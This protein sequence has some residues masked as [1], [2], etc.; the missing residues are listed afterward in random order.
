MSPLPISQTDQTT[1]SAILYQDPE[2]V[3]R[4]LGNGHL[5][6]AWFA[7]DQ[8]E[9][10]DYNRVIEGVK[11]IGA[12]RLMALLSQLFEIEVLEKPR[13]PQRKHEIVLAF[14][15]RIGMHSN[16]VKRYCCRQRGAQTPWIPHY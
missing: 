1:T 2:I 4:G 16:G 12:A 14:W 6:C 15:A 13:K 7:A 9:I 8:L 3:A 5:F 10:L 11:S